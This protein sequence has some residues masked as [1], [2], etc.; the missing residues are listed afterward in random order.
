MWRCRSPPEKAM[1]SGKR[2]EEE[3]EGEGEKRKRNEEKKKKT[4]Q[5]EKRNDVRRV[6]EI[7][8][9]YRKQKQNTVRIIITHALLL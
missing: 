1:A 9:D 4:L 7:S 3:E 5:I 6:K 2:N 8:T